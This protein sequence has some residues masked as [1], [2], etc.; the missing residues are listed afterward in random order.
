[1]PR[2]SHTGAL[3]S[4]RRRRPPLALEDGVHQL[5]LPLALDELVLD[6][7]ALAAHPDP[8]EDA[9]RG[10]VAYLQPADH[11]VQI[12]IVET[13]LE[14]RTRRLG[15]ESPA[16]VIGMDDEADLTL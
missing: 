5:A 2:L 10:R 12:E 4:R 9:G 6:Q 15:G 1:M 14:Q 13:Q 7:V 16:L 3:P 11:A 8:L